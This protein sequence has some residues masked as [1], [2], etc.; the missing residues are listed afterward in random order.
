MAVVSTVKRNYYQDSMKL[1][2]ISQKLSALPGVGKASAIM[3]T[4]ANLKMLR[5]AEM[6]KQIPESASANDLIVTI[7]AESEKAAKEA[8]EKLDSFLSPA[9]FGAT[10]KTEHKSL[11]SAYSALPQANLA[12]ISVPGQ[13]AKI[14]VAKA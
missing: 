2:Q 5:D 7:E 14:E 9:K 4:E 8:I 12:I 6:I 13:Y 1:M 11:D 10:V 3:A